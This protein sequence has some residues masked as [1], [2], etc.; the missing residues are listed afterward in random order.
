MWFGCFG[1]LLSHLFLVIF[2]GVYCFFIHAS[3]LL[4]WL[5]SGGLLLSKKSLTPTHLPGENPTIPKV[6]VQK[7]PHLYMPLLLLI[8]VFHCWWLGGLFT[9]Y[10]GVSYHRFW[11]FCAVSPVITCVFS[12]SLCLCPSNTIQVPQTVWE[13]GPSTGLQVVHPQSHALTCIVG[14]RVLGLTSH[15]TLRKVKKGAPV[16]K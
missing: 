14:T 10:S 6:F 16:S 12:R 13:A 8:G 1:P 4:F 15:A 3:L 11:L 7:T 5:L 2:V 9:F